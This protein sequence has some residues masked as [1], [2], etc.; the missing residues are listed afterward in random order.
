[1][2]W[3]KRLPLDHEEQLWMP[4]WFAASSVAGNTSAGRGRC[5]YFLHP[6]N[7]FGPALPEF[8]AL[9]LLFPPWKPFSA[10]KVFTRE[11]R[12]SSTQRCG[13]NWHK[14]NELPG[15]KSN[16]LS[17]NWQGYNLVRTWST[18]MQWLLLKSIWLEKAQKISWAVPEDKQGESHDIIRL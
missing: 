11:P 7:P 13:G 1:M 16:Y 18:T 6:G 3:P 12:P 10:S 8:L 9:R 14:A 15:S 4:R 5:L 17:W 2:Q